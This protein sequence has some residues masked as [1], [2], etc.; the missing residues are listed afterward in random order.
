MRS[1]RH[2]HTQQESNYAVLHNKNCL[3]ASAREKDFLHNLRRKKI[4]I[5]R[6]CLARAVQCVSNCDF[7]TKA[8]FFSRL[9]VVFMKMTQQEFLILPHTLDA[10]PPV[11]RKKLWKKLCTSPTF[12]FW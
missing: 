1:L 10:P 4:T 8:Y 3:D 5:L 12:L 7:K 6:S 2:W 11:L 9:D